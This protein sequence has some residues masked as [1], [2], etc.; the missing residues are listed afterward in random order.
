MKIMQNKIVLFMIIMFIFSFMNV[1]VLAEPTV[2]NIYT[3]PENP[4]PQ[5][6]VAIIADISGEDISSVNLSVSECNYDTGQCYEN[7]RYEMTL[8]SEGKYETQITLEDTKDRTDHIQYKVTV[9]D[10][11]V[12]Y[13]FT[14]ESLITDLDLSSN[15]ADSNGEENNTGDTSGFEFIFVLVALFISLLIYYKKR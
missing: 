9:I 11:D 10:N 4:E 6:S 14:D 5:S 12:E 15:N 2:N 8:N 7:E 13:S 3:V 1:T